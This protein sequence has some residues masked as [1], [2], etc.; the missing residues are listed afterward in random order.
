MDNE[1]QSKSSPF[2]AILIVLLIALP[3]LYFLSVGPAVCLRD[4]GMINQGTL[5]TVYAPVAWMDQN[6]PMFRQALESYVHLWASPPPEAS[7]PVP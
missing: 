4:H 7:Q 1:R 5:L 6:V 2:A 3:T